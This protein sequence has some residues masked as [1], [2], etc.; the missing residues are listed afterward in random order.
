MTSLTLQ[1]PKQRTRNLDS[2]QLRYIG[3]VHELNGPLT[4]AKLNLEQY[5][6]LQD[7]MNL[8]LLSANLQLIEDYLSGARDFIKKRPS[9]ASFSVNLALSQIEQ[10]FSTL[11]RQRNVELVF[12]SHG[13][14]KLTGDEVKFKQVV[15]SIIKNAIEAYSLG[16]A[17]RQ[18]GVVVRQTTEQGYLVISVQDF[19][20]GIRASQRQKIFELFYS[21]KDGSSGGLGVGLS[22]VRQ[23]ISEVF[24]GRVEFSSS[25]VSG[26]IFSLYFKL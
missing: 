1:K 19:G 10:N 13:D 3:L 18:P 14:I 7:P 25:R 21:T 26:T 22:L 23:M 15:S 24:D 16:S 12:I 6:S 4:A 20:V 11:A 9:K 17:K 2:E 5:V 8:K